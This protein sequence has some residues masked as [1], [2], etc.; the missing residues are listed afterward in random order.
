[1]IINLRLFLYL[2]LS[3]MLLIIALS[4]LLS[5]HFGMA[6]ITS[7][8]SG[9][10]IYRVTRPPKE[11]GV[12]KKKYAYTP[13]IIEDDLVWLTYYEEKYVHSYYDE[14]IYAKR[15]LIKE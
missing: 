5:E 3:F 6:V 2:T 4:F 7:V 8:I 12:V 11:L 13:V 15:S 10:I 14:T 9:F 1:M